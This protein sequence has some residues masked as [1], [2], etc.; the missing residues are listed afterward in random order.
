MTRTTEHVGAFNH[1][2]RSGDWD[3]FATRFADDAVMAFVGVPAGP[4][5]GRPAIAQA[6][7][8]NPPTETM[9]LLDVSTD[10]GADTARFRW[11]SGSTG[12]MLLDWDEA[13]LVRRLT[14]TFD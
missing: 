13:G 11:D 10:D 9:E 8:D 7:R 5:A 12:S 1:A 14:V 2:V 3:T 6:Y 4:Y